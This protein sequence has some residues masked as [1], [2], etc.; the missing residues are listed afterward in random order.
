MNGTRDIGPSQISYNVP[1]V[2][3]QAEAAM[4]PMFV[5]LTLA[6]A[7]GQTPP[8][9]E[10]KVKVLHGT[11]ARISANTG[12]LVIKMG[13]EKN[14]KQESFQVDKITRYWGADGGM[15]GEGLRHAGFKVG[16]EVWFVVGTGG[17]GRTILE[18]R[19]VGPLPPPGN[20]LRD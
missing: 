7:G 10:M 11:I 9:P 17:L 12:L 8:P 3:S 4:S 15:L 20:H 6:V 5:C 2:P 19:L 13:D 16:A 1:W 18:F 14:F